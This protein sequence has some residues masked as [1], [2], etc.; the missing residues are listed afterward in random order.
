MMNLSINFIENFKTIFPKK[1][2]GEK[3]VAYLTALVLPIQSIN[4]A[5]SQW[6]NSKRYTLQFT[7]QVIYLEHILNDI[8]DPVNRLIYIED[9]VVIAVDLN[10]VF[11]N[12]EQQPND[13]VT[14]Y[15]IGEPNPIP[16]P[17]GLYYQSELNIVPHFIVKVPNSILSISPI[18]STNIKGIVNQ[19][20][21][22]GKKYLIEGF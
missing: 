12:I 21:I 14:Y 15:D 18:I 9:P 19:Y 8:F 2:R 6:A 20:K 17:E 4:N 3:V 11:Y 5:F 1:I 10:A 22:A 13:L 16:L 7:G